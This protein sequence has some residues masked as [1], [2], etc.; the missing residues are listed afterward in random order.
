MSKYHRLPTNY[1]EIYDFFNETDKV[2]ALNNNLVSI[3]CSLGN[4]PMLPKFS[5]LYNNIFNTIEIVEQDVID[6]R[7][8]G[9]HIS[10]L[11]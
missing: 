7:K 9:K 8:V 2:E 1:M 10:N 3:S 4:E 6:V 11:R 5:L